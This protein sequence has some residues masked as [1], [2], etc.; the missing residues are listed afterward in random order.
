MMFII[1]LEI[2]LP[3]FSVCP[4]LLFILSG[5]F[6]QPSLVSAVLIFFG[7]PYHCGSLF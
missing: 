1:L 2:T 4:D 7:F 5:Y 6:S 3:K